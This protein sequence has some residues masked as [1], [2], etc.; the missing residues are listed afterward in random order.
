VGALSLGGVARERLGLGQVGA[1]LGEQRGSVSVSRKP[2]RMTRGS[3]QAGS[4]ATAASRSASGASKNEPCA[5]A[6]SRLRERRAEAVPTGLP[7]G[8]VMPIAR[9]IRRWR[10]PR[11]WGR[12]QAL[13]G[14][15]HLQH[16]QVVEALA[17]DLQADRQPAR[18]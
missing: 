7:R 5:T 12:P 2:A 9:R 8:V 3:I 1:G 15:R 13:P 6:P 17:D 14:A 4:A 18:C 11:P 16:A 10:R